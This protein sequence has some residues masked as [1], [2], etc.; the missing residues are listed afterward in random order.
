MSIETTVPHAA[1]WLGFAGA[2]P[3]VAGALASLPV[4][5]PLRPYGLALLL[6]YGAIILSFMGGVHWGAA[7]LRN[8]N[9]LGPLGRSVISSLVALPAPLIGGPAGLALLAAGFGGLLV[10]DE[11]ETRAGRLPAWYP[12]LRRPLTVIVVACLIIGAAARFY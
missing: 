11:Q 7:M 10:Y 9:G 4:A 5:E 12:Q 1:K 6:D 3:F 2:I 8:D